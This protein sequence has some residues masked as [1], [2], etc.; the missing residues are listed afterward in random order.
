LPEQLAGLG[1]ALLRAVR[2][3]HEG[4]LLYYPSVGRHIETP[5]GWWTV[6]PQPR[7]ATLA[8]TVRGRP[9]SFASDEEFEVVEQPEGRSVLVRPRTDGVTATVEL[10]PDR[11]SY[12][13]FVLKEEAQLPTV[14]RIMRWAAESRSRRQ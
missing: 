10:R 8:I 14:L 3:E 7:A 12:T 13:R 11:G 9:N 4:D 2:V 1:N 6:K 5:D